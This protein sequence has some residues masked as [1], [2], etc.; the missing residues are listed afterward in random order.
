MWKFTIRRI[1]I[2]IPQVFVLS[3][4]IF[5]LAQMMPGDALTG[6]IDPNIDPASVAAKREALG[7]NNPWYVQY[8]D[9]IKGAFVGDFGLCFRF[10]I[11]VYE[12]IVLRMVNIFLLSLV[13]YFLNYT[14][15]VLIGI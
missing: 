9:W 11:L 5:V 4:F 15:A 12:I 7:L 8:F 10:K 1:L 2:M 6:L 3:V 14:I 13:T